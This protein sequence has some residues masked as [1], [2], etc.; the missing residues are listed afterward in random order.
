ML[1]FGDWFFKRRSDDYTYH[2]YEEANNF[3]IFEFAWFFDT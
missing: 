2:K 1:Y 3:F